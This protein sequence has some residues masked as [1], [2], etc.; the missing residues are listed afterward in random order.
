MRLATTRR[1]VEL[2][3]SIL[4]VFVDL[5]NGRLIRTSVAIVGSTEDR[6][7]ILLMTPIVSLHYELMRP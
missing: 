5:H 2:Q 6:D 3:E 7:D 1:R 4:E